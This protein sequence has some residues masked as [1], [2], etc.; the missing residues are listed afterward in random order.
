M[1][2]AFPGRGNMQWKSSLAEVA[3]LSL[4]PND[5]LGYGIPDFFQLYLKLAQIQTYPGQP[6][7]FP[8]PCVDHVRWIL[9]DDWDDTCT[10][11]TDWF[12]EKGA[13][14]M[15]ENVPPLASHQFTTSSRALNQLRPGW[16]TVRI[17]NQHRTGHVRV[18]K[19]ER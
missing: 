11:R 17:S 3:N 7:A 16:Y 9:P 14:V 6:S 8:N 19:V 15:S 18:V 1:M 13:L 10:L 2:S 12:D 5:S 4:S